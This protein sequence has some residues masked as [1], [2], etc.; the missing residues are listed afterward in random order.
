MN[1]LTSHEGTHLNL[2]QRLFKTLIEAHASVH[3]LPERH[4]AEL[5]AALSLSFSLI[6]FLGSWATLQFIGFN[7]LIV[8]GL[9]FSVVAFAAYL[10]SRGT[11]YSRAPLIFVGGFSLLVYAASLTGAYP[12]LFFT[13]TFAI[14]FLLSNLF[15][16]RWM[17]GFIS[18]HLAAGLLV[19]IVF[20]PQLQG[21]EALNAR[22]GIITIGLFVVLFAWYRGNLER[23]RLEEIAETQV[24]LE[25]T[26]VDLQEAHHE[27]DKRLA[28]LRLAGEVGRAVSQ[29]R[30]VDVMLKDAAELIRSRFDLYYVQVYLVDASQTH[31]VLQSG[32][33]TVGE[34]L[35]SRAHQLPLDITSINGRAAFEKSSVVIADTTQSTTF[36]QNP[37][38]PDTRAEAAIPLIVNE[39]VVGVLDMQG[40]SPNSLT[41]ESL[42]AFEALA[43]QLAIAL[44]NASLLA[45]AEQARVD[46]EKQTARLARTNWRDYLDAIHRPEQI[47]FI[48]DQHEVKAFTETDSPQMPVDG[49]TV[50]A[51]ISVAGEALGELVAELDEERQNSQA[52]ELIGAV[53]HQVAQQIESLRLIESSERYRAQAE[54]TSRRLTREGWKG[55]LDT[56]ASQELGYFYDLVQVKSVGR[57]GRQQPE[58]PAVNL[59]LKIHNETVG[60]LAVLGLDADDK[61]SLDL[62]NAVMERLAAHIEGLR[63]SEQSEKRAFELA[64]IANVS[65]TASS[66]LDPAQLLQSVVDLTKESFGFY[67]AHIYL[68]NETGDTLELAFGAGEVGRQMVAEDHRI[69]LDVEKSLVAR[70]ARNREGFFV[71]DVHANPDFLSHPLLPNTASELAVPMIAGNKV[72]GV[73]DVQ[74]DTKDRFNVDDVRIQTTLAAQVSVAVQNARTFAQAQKQAEREAMLNAISQKIQSATTVEAVLQIAARE[75]GHA[76][77][78]PLTVAQLGVRSSER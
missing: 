48:Y 41:E 16:F 73:L 53:A 78:A 75:L 49:G 64:T 29:V 24:E 35:L 30:S 17:V 42:P 22:A 39:R 67:H 36:R 74:A 45:E 13:L 60:N 33:G 58:E 7:I 31:L 70:A 28:E 40:S 23:M 3:S 4:K 34:Q 5:L 57:N 52:N 37:L 66:T 6:V 65:T 56:Q 72:V 9:F 69:P 11:W 21:Q 59:P 19:S 38:L 55:Y 14:L 10:M 25:H 71:N 54:E 50:T 47:G 27:V 77:G 44:Q 62:A 76:L 43:G 2:G 12:G 1:T 63:L 61:Q 26:N 51:T 8:A 68:L 46:L 32:T 18:F 20:M 15:D